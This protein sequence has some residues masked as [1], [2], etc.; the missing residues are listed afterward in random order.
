M[1]V[2]TRTPASLVCVLQA[3]PACKPIRTGLIECICA[4][5]TTGLRSPE[6]FGPT[7]L[8]IPKAPALGL[9]LE[10]PQFESYNRKIGAQVGQAEVFASRK[11]EGESGSAGVEAEAEGGG[12][13]VREQV[14][15]SGIDEAVE[16]FKREV[17]FLAMHTEEEKDDTYAKW[18]NLHDS[19]LG[20]DF[21]YLNAKGVIRECPLAPRVVGLSRCLWAMLSSRNVRVLSAPTLGKK[22]PERAPKNTDGAESSRAGVVPKTEEDDDEE[23]RL[24]RANK[25]KASA[26]ME[27]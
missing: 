11:G 13:P 26:D 24:A 22:K 2:R 19:Q 25:G 20:D 4:R 12:Y 17:V 18:L 27:G 10:Q 9:L 21:D 1:A 5:L 8:N 6:T 7:R 3:R 23:A 14:E 16:K 15:Y